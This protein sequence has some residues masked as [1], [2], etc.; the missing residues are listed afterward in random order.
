MIAFFARR[1]AAPV[2]LLLASSLPAFA[3]DEKPL[4]TA[5]TAWLLTATAL[6]LFMTLPGLALFYAGLVRARNALSVLMHCVVIA[7][8][9]SVLWLAFG[10]SLAF[11]DGGANQAWIGG[12]ERAFLAGIGADTLK[13]GIPEAVFFMF[14][15]TFAIITPALIVGAYPE[16]IKFSAVVWF[17]ALWL[18]LVYVPVCHWIW[19]GGWLFEVGVIDFAGGLVVH[20]TAGMAAVAAALMVGRR[21]DFP[22]EPILPHNPGMTATGAGMLWV[23]WYGF[24]A[25]SALAANGS[26]GMAMLATHMSAAAGALTW[27]AIEW[28]RHGR[29]SLVGTVTGLIAG[30]ATITPAAGVAG[31]VGGLIAG[32]CGGV[33]CFSITSLLKQRLKLDDSL[34][35]CAVHGVGGALGILLVAIIGQP[36]FGGSGFAEGVDALTQLGS[37]LLGL[38][39]TAIWAG[40]VSWG[41]LALLRATSGL[42]VSEEEEFDGLDITTHGER[43]YDL[44]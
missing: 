38:A 25:G 17:S 3:A 12:L 8:L 41:I 44:H 24:N 1:L 20:V 21:R 37:Q 15:L 42:R 33:V 14:Q 18:L 30:L 31:P 26:A 5:S 35:V 34:D 40:G 7:A 16:R 10:Y 29:P 19:G 2:L 6:V 27:M 9:M 22:H 43:A 36:G 28:L 39:A 11:S 4:D 13:D 23:G 32:F